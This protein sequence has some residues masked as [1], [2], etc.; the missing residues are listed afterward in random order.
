MTNIQKFLVLK[1]YRPYQRCFD[2]FN[3]ERFRNKNVRQLSKNVGF[4]VGFGVML[5]LLVVLTILSFWYCLENGFNV[6]ILSVSMPL[7]LSFIQL[8]LTHISLIMQNRVIH[9][10]IEDL[11]EAVDE[12]KFFVRRCEMAPVSR[13]R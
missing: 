3:G 13:I 12:R 2:A 5:V 9:A 8:F 6:D 7:I 11:Q 10:T 4:A 1:E